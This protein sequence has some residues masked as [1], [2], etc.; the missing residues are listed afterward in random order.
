MAASF[1]Y[2]WRH[3]LV[4]TWRFRR[5]PHASGS[6]AIDQAAFNLLGPVGGGRA[7]LEQTLAHNNELVS[8]VLN[9]GDRGGVLM[10]HEVRPIH[11]AT[12]DSSH[13]A[14]E[15]KK[16]IILLKIGISYGYFDCPL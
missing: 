4:T 7:Q 10:I 6:P 15:I 5:N 3:H 13:S 1:R 11:S 14:D 8:H 12:P 2:R 9:L 16:H